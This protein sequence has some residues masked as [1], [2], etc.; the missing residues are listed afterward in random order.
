MAETSQATHKKIPAGVT[1]PGRGTYP[2]RRPPSPDFCL[3][4]SYL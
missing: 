4:P 2:Q 1:F 3:L